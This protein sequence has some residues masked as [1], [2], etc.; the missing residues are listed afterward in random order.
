[1]TSDSP[2]YE[3]LSAIVSQIA[4]V[5]SITVFIT[6]TYRVVQHA[7]SQRATSGIPA[8]RPDES[9]RIF[10][11]AGFSIVRPELWKSEVVSNRN[12]P[13]E[14]SIKLRS[15]FNVRPG[16]SLDVVKLASEPALHGHAEEIRFQGQPARL[17]RK[18]LEDPGHFTV[19]LTFSRDASFWLL[20][21]QLHHDQHA[22]PERM[23]EYMETFSP[24][25]LEKNVPGDGNGQGPQ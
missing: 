18:N 24:H 3:R 25:P 23:W 22:I 4:L 13:D 11:P 5:A 1:M 14:G 10:H 6:F 12:P 7:M 16:A 9:R 19:E 21:Y 8:E 15:P 20:R 2:R 17:T